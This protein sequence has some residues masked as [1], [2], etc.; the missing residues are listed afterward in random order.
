MGGETHLDNRKE[1][2]S[3]IFDALESL[4]HEKPYI[5]ISINDICK[6]AFISKPTFYRYFKNKENIVRWKTKQFFQEGLVQIGRTCSWQEGYA[7]TTRLFYE[8]R[9][10]FEDEQSPTFV[11]DFFTFLTAYQENCLIET[12]TCFKGEPVSEKLRIQIKALTIAQS[13][14]TRSWATEGMSI[15]PDVFAEYLASIVPHD[16]FKLFN[17]SK[18]HAC[19]KPSIIK[20]KS[21]QYDALAMQSDCRQPL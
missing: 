1:M 17:D 4:L 7:I 5:E 19:L 12:I 14:I 20:E 3:S 13:R 11:A 8:H 18:R 6:K 9:S 2:K 10:I 16:L 15:P 21:I